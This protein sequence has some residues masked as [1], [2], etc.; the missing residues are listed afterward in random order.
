M[1]QKERETEGEMFSDKDAF[2]T[3]SYIRRLKERA[4]IEERLK[5]EAEIES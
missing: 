3:P 1:V 2:V 4:E 5:K